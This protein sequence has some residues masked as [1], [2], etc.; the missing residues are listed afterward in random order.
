MIISRAPL[1]L[2][3]GGGGTDLASYY[4]R[5]GG[6]FIS[7]AIDKYIFLSVKECFEKG[8]RLSYSEIEIVD[9]TDQI[10]HQIF[11]EVLKLFGIEDH[12]EAVS[13]GDIAA[14]NGLGSSGSFTVSLLNALHAFKG[15]SA[16][17]DQIAE[18]ACRIEIE[19]LGRPVGK[20]DQYIAAF[21]GLR[22]FTIDP[23]GKVRVEPLRISEASLREL[24]RNCLLFHT[25]IEREAHRILRDQDGGVEK[26]DQEIIEALHK[27]KAIGLE[28][29]RALEDGDVR[30]FGELLDLHWSTKKGL[31]GRISNPVLDRCYEI[32]RGAG[33]LGGKVIGAGGGG[34]FL[35][36]CEEECGRLIEAL[37]DEGL[38][39]MRFHFDFE[40]VRT[41][42]D[43]TARTSPKHKGA[44]P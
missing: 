2:S 39:L 37:E 30:R 13:I 25:G 28:S 32:A 33:A 34:F 10:R 21:G 22:C 4:S 12:F 40:G 6:F 16:T 31:S 9:H 44:A 11:R 20:Q 1:R 35:F 18:E 5:F 29:R 26:G 15:E 8:I 43:A 3:L 7:G 19:V 38:R 24:E 17:R 36:Y 42:I 23:A 41:I 27:I 14:R